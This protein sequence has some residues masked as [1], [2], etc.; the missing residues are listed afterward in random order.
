[1]PT[2]KQMVERHGISNAGNTVSCNQVLLKDETELNVEKKKTI[3]K[4]VHEKQSRRRRSQ[5][6]RPVGAKKNVFAWELRQCAQTG[7]RSK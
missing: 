4:S 3:K 5:S 2:N 6:A 1:M 7:G